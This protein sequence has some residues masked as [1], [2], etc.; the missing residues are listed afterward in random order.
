MTPE[1]EGQRDGIPDE[2]QKARLI[3]AAVSDVMEEEILLEGR[4]AVAVRECPGGGRSACAKLDQARI[5]VFPIKQKR[6]RNRTSG[7]RAILLCRI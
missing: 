5:E 7:S 6:Q 4:D 1:R 2:I 3:E